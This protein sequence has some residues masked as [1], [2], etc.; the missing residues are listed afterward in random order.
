MSIS[1]QV[2]FHKVLNYKIF[3]KPVIHTVMFIKI[4][5]IGL[6]SS[7]R[8]TVATTFADGGNYHFHLDAQ[9][10]IEFI[11]VVGIVIHTFTLI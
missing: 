7:K 9:N 2:N 1:L 3:Y 5:I 10:E 6:H 11:F 4:K 8:F